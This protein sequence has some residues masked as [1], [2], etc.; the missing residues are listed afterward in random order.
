MSDIK[1]GSKG[2]IVLVHAEKG[3]GMAIIKMDSRAMAILG[4]GLGVLMQ[5]QEHLENPS[6]GDMAK[7]AKTKELDSLLKYCRE[8]SLPQ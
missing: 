8:S 5:K 3:S 7:A 6:E 2:A 4:E 1:P